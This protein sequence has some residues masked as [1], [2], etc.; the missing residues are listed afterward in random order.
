MKIFNNLISASLKLKKENLDFEIVVIGKTKRLSVDD[1]NNQLL[2][3]YIFNYRVNF[4]TLYRLVDSSD[5]ILITLDPDNKKDIS[6]KNQ[7]VTGA[8]QLSYGFFKP[9]LMNDYYKTIY[10]ITKENSLLYSNNDFYNIMKKA[11]NLNN[12]DYKVIQKNLIELENNI[13]K[14]SIFNVKETLCSLLN[15]I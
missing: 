6:Y 7:R 10:N 1:I 12:N 5:F 3:N 8:I 13:Y 9:V 2:D 15:N 14:Q 4:T 11:I